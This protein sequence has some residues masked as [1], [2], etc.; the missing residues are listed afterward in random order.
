L[1]GPRHRQ[2]REIW[3]D[4]E[5]GGTSRGAADCRMQRQHRMP[6]GRYDPRRTLQPLYSRSSAGLDRAETGEG[7]N[8]ASCRLRPFRRRWRDHQVEI[9]KALSAN[10]M[11]KAWRKVSGVYSL[12]ADADLPG[13]RSGF[14][15]A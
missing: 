1:L 12:F 2:V 6:A 14:R 10:I 4:A 11:K 3:A 13:K 9:R 8:P 5:G 15:F 7:E